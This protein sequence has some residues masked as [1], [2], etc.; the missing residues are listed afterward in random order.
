MAGATSSADF[1]GFGRTRIR[2]VRFR[3]AQ[4]AICR[5][6]FGEANMSAMNPSFASFSLRPDTLPDQ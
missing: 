3:D 4:T 5:S 6:H 2:D 1:P